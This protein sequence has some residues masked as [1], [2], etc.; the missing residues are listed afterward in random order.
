MSYIKIGARELTTEEALLILPTFEQVFEQIN[1]IR[2][3]L[4]GDNK[5]NIQKTNNIGILGCRGAGKT[6]LLKTISKRLNDENKGNDIIL[7]IIVPENMSHSS[8]LM[9]TILGLFKKEVDKIKK[10]EQNNNKNC[11]SEY[12]KFGLFQKYNEV[13]KQ[14]TF[15]QKEYREILINEFTTENEYVKK[16][17]EIF[18]SDIE[19]ISKFNEF[20][21]ALV[22]NKGY[23]TLIFFFIDDIDLST[24]RCIDVVKTLLSY[25]SHKNI[26]TF[27][28]GDID[29]FE[30]AITIDFLRQENALT[31]QVWDGKFLNNNEKFI[32]RKKLLAYE[33]LKKI[34]PPIYRHNV[35]HWSLEHRGNYIIE[36]ND[37]K[38]DGDQ[39]IKGTLCNL[40][41]KTLSTYIKP[42]LFIFKNYKTNT[43]DENTKN[44]NELLPYMYHLFDD[45][46]RGLNNVYIALLLIYKRKKE[47]NLISFENKKMLIETIASSKPVFNKFRDLLFGK[48]IS[49]GSNEESTLIRIDNFNQ[50]VMKGEISDV[51]KFQLFIFIEFVLKIIHIKYNTGKYDKVKKKAINILINNPEISGST[52]N[53]KKQYDLKQYDLKKYNKQIIVNYNNLIYR[54]LVKSSLEFSFAFY[55]NMSLDSYELVSIIGEGDDL[56][57]SKLQRCIWNLYLSFKSCAKL[58]ID[59]NRNDISELNMVKDYIIKIYN[60]FS[61]ELAYIQDSL[62]SNKDRNLV[63]ITYEDLIPEKEIIKVH[64]RFY[65]T[66]KN[67]Q[68]NITINNNY[69]I[70]KNY[71]ILIN[72]FIYNIIKDKSIDINIINNYISS[73]I[74]QKEKNR[75]NIICRINQ[76]NMWN[77]SLSEMVKVYIEETIIKIILNIISEGFIDVVKFKNESYKKFIDSYKGISKTVAYKTEENINQILEG[78]EIK[79]SEW[80]TVK[81]YV[82]NLAYN[83]RVV[84]GQ[85]EAQ[86]ML[87]QL[88][89]LYIGY[90]NSEKNEIE[91]LE[92]LLYFYSKYTNEE[93]TM[94][95]ILIQSTDLSNFMKCISESQKEVN[96]NMINEYENLINKDSDLSITIK[97]LEEL[98]Y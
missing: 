24:N 88:N 3:S 59:K 86:Q 68:Q 31:A 40:L 18:N 23:N 26:I 5:E 41:T 14:Y 43:I 74:P 94:N 58:D 72:N 73:E 33:Y 62:S 45:T 75:L 95:D 78:N 63:E 27:I 29:T 17:N 89:T 22:A 84:Y 44:N 54:F 32:E 20:I 46:S 38:V 13:I 7:P 50:I 65:N 47:D 36:G 49:F 56:K 91:L 10:Q 55:R 57:V 77:H 81:K 9:A 4:S 87:N 71:K 53:I 25:V 11:I 60:N 76:N 90:K 21:E 34:I 51:E 80:M 1:N 97:E 83:N 96:K 98:F 48:I 16:T 28:S 2:D 19:F 85:Y 52:Y 35:K 79:F 82:S 93:N 66:I 30:E 15:I 61:M 39:I 70:L 69:E 92:I 6:S 8:T 37:I 67:D 12:D 64:E 42:S